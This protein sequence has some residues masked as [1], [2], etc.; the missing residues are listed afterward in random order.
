M[1]NLYR[2]HDSMLLSLEYNTRTVKPIY[3]TERDGF[4]QYVNAETGFNTDKE[5]NTTVWY[6]KFPQIGKKINKYWGAPN[7]ILDIQY[8]DYIESYK[9]FQAEL[10]LQ[11]GFNWDSV[12][13][14]L[15]VLKDSLTNVVYKS[16][17]LVASDFNI[18][19]KNE[20][21]NGTFWAS[22]IK[23]WLPDI[24][25]LEQSVSFAVE[26]I[27]FEDIHNDNTILIYPNEFEALIPDMPLSDKVSVGL[28]FNDSLMLE[29]ETKSLLPEYTVEQLLKWN[30]SIPEI[31]NI[32][33]QHL[34]KFPSDTEGNYHE[35]LVSNEV[36][37]LNKITIGLPIIIV[38][39]NQTSNPTPQVIEVTTFFKING[40]LATRYSTILWD[41]HEAMNTFI[42]KYVATVNENTTLNPVNVVEEITINNNIIDTIKDLKITQISV[43]TYVELI[44]DKKVNAYNKNIAFNE[45]SFESYM[46]IYFDADE[47]S[48]K[49]L[50][51][52]A[53]KTLE[54]KYYF[55]IAEIRLRMIES[56]TASLNFKVFKY[57]DGKLV[58]SGI[59]EK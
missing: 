10:L 8:L 1:E 42:S 4:I 37:A 43:P 44:T 50:H 7:N 25:L 48:E 51:I 29:I 26:I 11:Q 40:L 57:S 12:F 41:Y 17:I 53:Q 54:N 13:G 9:Q 19:Y 2:V 39:A 30:F 20:L 35:L 24:M 3:K 36:Y 58:L 32:S 45:V 34:I 6:S 15:F 59:I 18:N 47:T 56:G 21:I 23:F 16:R 14:I 49:N 5:L 55:D 28:S 31:S 46:K 38:N 22:S 33:V 52:L 27:K